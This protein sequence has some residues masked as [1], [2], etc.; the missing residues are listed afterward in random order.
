M[1]IVNTTDYKEYAKN[2][3]ESE[4]NVELKENNNK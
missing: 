3:S 4:Q 2:T 1:G